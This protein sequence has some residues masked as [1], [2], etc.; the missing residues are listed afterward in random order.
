MGYES[1]DWQ[2][3]LRYTEEK[4][5]SHVTCQQACDDHVFVM[6]MRSFIGIRIKLSFEALIVSA[7]NY[8]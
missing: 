4:L 3:H 7:T 5:A 2:P 6:L 8:K 1:C